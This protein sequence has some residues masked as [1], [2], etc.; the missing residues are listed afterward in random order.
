MGRGALVIYF[1][2]IENREVCGD[3]GL[4]YRDDTGLVDRMRQT[5]E[6]SED[7]RSQYRA[8]AVARI[9][10]KYDWDVVTTQYETL[11]RGLR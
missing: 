3:A 10:A 7:E 9:K 1:D 6:M 11:L 2:T 4:P 8:K 5:L